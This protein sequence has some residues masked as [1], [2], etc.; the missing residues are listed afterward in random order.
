MI[1]SKF[2]DHRCAVTSHANVV[3]Q[4]RRAPTEKVRCLVRIVVDLLPPNGSIALAIALCPLMG[5]KVNARK[6]AREIP[7][8]RTPALSS[9]HALK[10]GARG[11]TDPLLAFNWF[12][13]LF[14]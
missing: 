7:P 4:G 1:L 6:A 11:S 10:D 12:P 3:W 2:V 13:G 8:V 9:L 14:R 5:D